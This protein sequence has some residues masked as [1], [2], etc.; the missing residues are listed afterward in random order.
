MWHGFASAVARTLGIDSG[1]LPLDA[2]CLLVLELAAPTAEEATQALEQ[3]LSA[4]WAEADIIDGAV[5]MSLEQA[6]TIWRLREESEVIERLHDHPPSFDVSVP[7]GAIDAY[8]TRI[9][10][11]L[12]AID[13]DYSPYVFGHL[14]DGNLHISINTDNPPRER[15]R[16]IE[17]VLYAGLQEI[18]GSFSAEHGVGLDKRDAYERH[19]DP[20][21][22]Q[23]SRAIKAL[24]DPS[25][26]L[27]PGKIVG[28][29]PETR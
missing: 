1:E 23:L 12:K 16:A 3:G 20:V 18:G 28:P 14:A 8:V 17:D 21:K 15:Y 19:A 7:G 22:Q 2:P 9:T 26:M 4:L 29:G 6:R 10:E 27:N 5:A 24:L 25:D 11:G 13:A